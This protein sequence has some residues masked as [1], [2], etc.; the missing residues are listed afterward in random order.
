MS[1]TEPLDRLLD[2]E[3]L[4][5]FMMREDSDDADMYYLTQFPRSDPFIFLR[6]DGESTIIVSQLE[7]SR[8]EDEAEV[9]NVVSTGEFDLE[10][11][12]DR[13]K[14][15]LKQV[16]DRFDLE[17]LA[18]PEDFP[19]KP[20][21]ELR[22]HVELEPV[23]NQ[24]MEARKTKEPGE[25]EN[26]KQAQKA[27]EEAMEH[28]KSMIQDTEVED[29]ELYLGGEPLTSE[30]VKRETRKFLLERDCSTPHGMIAACG[31]DSA[32][33]HSTG[34]GALRAGEPIVVD[35]FPKHDNRYF[36]DMTRTFVKEEMSEEL[37]RIKEAVVE[38]RE[39]AFDVLEQGAGVDASEVHD[40]VC[41]VF[42]ER[43]F[44]TLRQ[45]DTES[46]FIHSTGHAV[47][48]ELH[49]PPGLGRKEEELEAGNV[50]TIEPGLYIPGV[51]GIRI[52]DM[53][54]VKENGYENF[55][56]MSTEAELNESSKS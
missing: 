20:A 37:W 14:E 33:P 47:G 1:R 3:G 56:S 5:A 9:D 39:A 50:L 26:L 12:E 7:Y 21:E 17:R 19:L 27:T 25:V 44:D 23:E 24:V 34:S 35:I 31:E 53:I 46:G 52:E 6:Q 22:E 48:L 8:A 43:G 45:G 36:G 2:K 32:R 10:E 11:A 54:I 30:K 38:A 51:G 40:A 49:E 16:V 15:M 29:G 42:E 28:V 55:N 4:D 18:V 13:R 41:D